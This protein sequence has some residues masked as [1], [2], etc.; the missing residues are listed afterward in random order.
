MARWRRYLRRSIKRQFT[1][2]MMFCLMLILIGA[3]MV[4]WSTVNLLRNYQTDTN[5]LNKKQ[6]YVSDITQHTNGTI[7]RVRG[8]YVLLTQFEYDK[9]SEERKALDQALASYKKLPLNQE[10]AQFAADIETFLTAYFKKVEQGIEYAKAGN[11]EA[12]RKTTNTGEN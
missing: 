6:E 5:Q 3:I 12:I 11:Y 10:E 8:Y 4:L 7:L 9:I 2:M 1:A